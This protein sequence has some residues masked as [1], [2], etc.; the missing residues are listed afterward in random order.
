MWVWILSITL[1]G[2]N[3][4]HSRIAKFETKQDCQKALISKKIEYEQKGREMVGHCFY[5]RIDSKGWW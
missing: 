4:E 1:I 2:S 3:P 5:G